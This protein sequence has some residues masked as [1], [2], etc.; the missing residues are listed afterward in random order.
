MTRHQ[1]IAPHAR[2]R[3]QRGS[4][5]AALSCNAINPVAFSNSRG[6][7]ERNR[8]ETTGQF[9]APKEPLYGR[10]EVADKQGYT[11][12]KDDPSIADSETYSSDEDGWRKA[13]EAVAAKRSEP[14]VPLTVFD[15]L[16][17]DAA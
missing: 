9:E 12:R 5:T 4:L 8:D 1:S 3:T 17:I 7:Y 2:E 11:I 14:D 10:E 15:V 16:A 6:L 13:A